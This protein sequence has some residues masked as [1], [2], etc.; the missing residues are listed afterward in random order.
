MNSSFSLLTKSEF[1]DKYMG[2]LQPL[3]SCVTV[4][5]SQHPDLHDHDILRVYEAL[6]KMIK[7]K[8]TNFPL[9]EN[10]LEGISREIYELQLG[11]LEDIKDSYSLHEIQACL[12][13]LEKSV[14][15][16]NREHGSRGYLNFIA[17]YT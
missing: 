1:A 7:A 4:F 13:M 17:P 3:E 15:L 2:I 14:K 8:L 16:W 11:F 9:P 6:L 12:K 10:Q 5:Y